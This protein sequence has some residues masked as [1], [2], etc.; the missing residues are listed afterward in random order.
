[1]ITADHGNAETMADEQGNPH[2]AHTLNPVRFILVDDTRKDVQLRE[3][4]LANIAPTILDVLGLEKPG[5]MTG[6]S[7]ILQAVHSVHRG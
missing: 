2:T 3:G 6:D 1:M 5:A 7:L 4:A